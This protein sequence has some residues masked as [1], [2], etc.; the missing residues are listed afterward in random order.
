MLGGRGGDE[1][2][3]VCVLMVTGQ[4]EI[5]LGG[6]V[7]DEVLRWYM[8]CVLMVT[9]Q[10]EI[11]LGGWVMSDAAVTYYNDIIDQ[12]T[13]G[14]DFLQQTL[15]PC[16]QSR[17]AWHVDQFGHSREHAALFSKVSAPSVSV[18]V[19]SLDRPILD[20]FGA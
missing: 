5:V 16:A 15:G 2:L 12:H 1:V 3:R 19:C 4:L 6:W 20:S 17:V 18:C 11:V 8:V 14:F 7:G 9:G 13:L 10:L